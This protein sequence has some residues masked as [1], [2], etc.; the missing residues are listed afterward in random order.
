MEWKKVNLHGAGGISRLCGTY[1]IHDVMRVPDGKYK[2]KVLQNGTENFIAL[3]N[4]CVRSVDGTPEWT[5][6]TG[7]TETEALEKALAALSSDLATLNGNV[8]RDR[9]AWSDPIEF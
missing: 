1:E 8:D 2:I 5:S 7:R 6:G 3:P 9:F 4:I